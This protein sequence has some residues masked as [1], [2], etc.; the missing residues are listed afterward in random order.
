MSG[1]KYWQPENP[2]GMP[3]WRPWKADEWPISAFTA[4]QLALLK[5]VFEEY[6][7]S[8]AWKSEHQHPNAAKLERAKALL[9]QAFDKWNAAARELGLC[10]SES[11]IKYPEGNEK[12]PQKP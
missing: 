3:A 4:D 10:S 11:Q 5:Q 2:Y 12:C 9:D 6:G 8:K 1:S 7:P